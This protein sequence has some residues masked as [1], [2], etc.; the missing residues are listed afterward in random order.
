MKVRT[1]ALTLALLACGSGAY[2][3]DSTSDYVKRS[4]PKG[5]SDA[6]YACI[7]KAGSDT[8]AVAA[9]LTD[10]KQ[11]QD[12]RLNSTYKTLMGKLDAKAKEKLVAA[13]RAWLDL[14]DKSG[15]FEIALYGHET[16]DDLQMSQNEVFRICER[17]N[18]L[19]KYLGVVDLK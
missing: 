9:C 13:E 4:A 18:V 6:F 12:A 10:E 1:F 8:I 17:A 7:D 2:A 3:A 16:V 15:R 11:K 19:G 14:Q 5:I